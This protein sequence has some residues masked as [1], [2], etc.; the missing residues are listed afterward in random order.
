MLDKIITREFC[1]IPDWDD[2]AHCRCR[3]AGEGLRA[4]HVQRKQM[5]PLGTLHLQTISITYL[6]SIQLIG[7]RLYL[8]PYKIHTECPKIYRKYVPHL[9]KYTANL[10]LNS[11]DFSVNFETLSNMTDTCII[12]SREA[13]SGNRC[14]I[15]LCSILILLYTLKK[16]ATI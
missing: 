2:H 11:T 3:F 9:L 1:L 16:I 7:I 5:S 4:H 12:K 14:L 15:R 13:S 10:Y 6:K 8:I